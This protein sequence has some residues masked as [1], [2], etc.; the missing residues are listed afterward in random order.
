MVVPKAVLTVAWMDATKVG[1]T[2][3]LTA[4][5]SVAHSA[6]KKVALMEEL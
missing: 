3:T 1:T 5:H 4:V 6:G 2:V